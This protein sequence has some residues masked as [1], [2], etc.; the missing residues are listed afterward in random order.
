MQ[1]YVN[2]GVYT[3]TSFTTLE[4]A[5]EVYGPFPTYEEALSVW[6]GM[7]RAQIDNCSHRLTVTKK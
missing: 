2:G 1:Y 6:A 7:A 4:S 5:E 3:D